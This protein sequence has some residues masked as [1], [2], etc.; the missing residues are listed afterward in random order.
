MVNLAKDIV[1]YL[2]IEGETL[3]GAPVLSAL[4][5]LA[6]ALL[7][8]IATKWRY[9]GII[10]HQKESIATQKNNIEL[11]KDQIS[12]NSKKKYELK[13]LS[14]KPI[15]EGVEKKSN[16]TTTPKFPKVTWLTAK[17]VMEICEWS[18]NILKQHIENGLP[19]YVKNAQLL[20]SID[21]KRDLI[22]LEMWP[23][24]SGSLSEQWRF[25]T[26][27]IEKYIKST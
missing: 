7:A 23:R 15:T 16:K 12:V 24:L 18:I 3:M 11:L 19:G 10:E 21:K 9:S 1:S 6:G 13:N 26:E 4:L 27:D 5:L 22:T 2:W 8:Y 25:K 17:D 14:K 20:R